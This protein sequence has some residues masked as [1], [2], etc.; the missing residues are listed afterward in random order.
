METASL[1]KA[2]LENSAVNTPTARIKAAL[3]TLFVCRKLGMFD[4]ANSPLS[5]DAPQG[6]AVRFVWEVKHRAWPDW[7]KTGRNS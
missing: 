7:D 6:N 2:T 4:P 3:D 5:H 1:K